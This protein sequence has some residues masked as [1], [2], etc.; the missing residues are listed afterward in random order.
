MFMKAWL[1]EQ[2]SFKLDLMAAMRAGVQFNINASEG[3]NPHWYDAGDGRTFYSLSAGGLVSPIGLRG[4]ANMGV[5][6]RAAFGRWYSP[7]S[8]WRVGIGTRGHATQRREAQYLQ[9]KT[10]SWR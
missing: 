1:S 4:K 7:V 6:A 5:T 2:A 10:L 9:R 3:I 8:A